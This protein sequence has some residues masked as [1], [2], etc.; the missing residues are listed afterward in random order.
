[1]LRRRA[2]IGLVLHPQCLDSGST[3][4]D[5]ERL[6]DALLDGGCSGEF[7]SRAAIGSSDKPVLHR[8]SNTQRGP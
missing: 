4:A 3:R 6:L 7:I 2:P 1:L 5:L 8:Q